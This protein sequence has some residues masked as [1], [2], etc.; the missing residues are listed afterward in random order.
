M[1]KINKWYAD[2]G[3]ARLHYVTEIKKDGC[4]TISYALIEEWWRF[5]DFNKNWITKDWTKPNLK[6]LPKKDM[7]K[8]LFEGRFEIV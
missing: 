6:A 2:L 7:F 5:N 1:I 3:R 8:N 4:I